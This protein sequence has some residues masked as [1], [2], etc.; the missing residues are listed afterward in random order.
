MSDTSPMK[1]KNNEVIRDKKEVIREKNARLEQRGL[2]SFETKIGGKRM[3]SRGRVFDHAFKLF[4]EEARATK[5]RRGQVVDE[6]SKCVS[7]STVYAYM[8]KWD[9]TLEDFIP[10]YI[11]ECLELPEVEDGQDSKRRKTADAGRDDATS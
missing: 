1:N 4:N 6:N 11:C 10:S 9:M 8:R 2:I 7:K 3:L 5:Q